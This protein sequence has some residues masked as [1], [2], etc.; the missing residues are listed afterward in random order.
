MFSDRKKGM[1]SFHLSFVSTNCASSLWN[2]NAYLF[3]LVY[4]DNIC[5]LRLK[6]Q[7][8]ILSQNW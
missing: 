5:G 8:Q 6:E 3:F 2:L 1:W 4:I 7:I